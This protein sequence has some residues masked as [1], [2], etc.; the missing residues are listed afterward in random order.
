[1]AKLIRFGVSLPGELIACFDRAIRSK[2][3]K[4]RSE[5]IGD[6]IR[7]S[8]IEDQWQRAE[9]NL[10]GTVTIVYSHDKHGLSDT[11][12]ALQHSHHD[13]IVCTT[14][15]HMDEHN[16]LEVVVVRGTAE[17]IRAISDRLISTTGVKHGKLVCTSAVEHF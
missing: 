12:N 4:T 11:L 3:Y 1:M 10:I 17:Q 8:L 7:E 13:A 16:C 9:G 6:L 14:H 15:V 5:A 2:G